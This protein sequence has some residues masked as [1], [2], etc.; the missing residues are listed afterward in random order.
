MTLSALQQIPITIQCQ[1]Y[2]ATLLLPELFHIKERPHLETMLQ[3]QEKV[4]C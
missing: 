2:Q 3:M 1:L 4:T